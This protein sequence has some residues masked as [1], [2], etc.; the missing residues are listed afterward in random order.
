ML[1]HR[2]TRSR[3]FKYINYLLIYTITIEYYT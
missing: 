1:A 3:D 2:A